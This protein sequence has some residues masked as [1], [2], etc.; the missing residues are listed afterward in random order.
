[1]FLFSNSVRQKYGNA[2]PLMNFSVRQ[3]QI[4]IM[5]DGIAVS[6]SSE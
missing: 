3:E 4:A 1:M 6:V 5:F 2:E